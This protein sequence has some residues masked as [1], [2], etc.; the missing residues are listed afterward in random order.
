MTSTFLDQSWCVT[1]P[2]PSAPPGLPDPSP[3]VPA[4]SGQML[5]SISAISGGEGRDLVS[6]KSVTVCK[7]VSVSWL[8]LCPALM[9]LVRLQTKACLTQTWRDEDDVA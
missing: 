1:E 8:W 6:V 5:S 2:G 3:A 7:N 9:L 4:V